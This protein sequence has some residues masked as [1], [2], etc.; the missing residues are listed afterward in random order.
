[1]L[2]KNQKKV[3]KIFRKGGEKCKI[4]LKKSEKTQKKLKKNL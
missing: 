3:S 4:F 1:M 2:K